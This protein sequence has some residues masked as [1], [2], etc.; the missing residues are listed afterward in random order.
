MSIYAQRRGQTQLTDTQL[1]AG[2]VENVSPVGGGTATTNVN[3]TRGS[4]EVNI[5]EEN[6]DILYQEQAAWSD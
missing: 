3:L 5:C 1:R 4:E 6:M 2:G